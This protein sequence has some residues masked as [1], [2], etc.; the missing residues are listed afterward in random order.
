MK[1]SRGGELSF[2]ALR[3]NGLTNDDMQNALTADMVQE[4]HAGPTSKRLAENARKREREMSG[5]GYCLAGVQYAAADTLGICYSNYNGPKLPGCSS[6][7]ACFSNQAWEQSG[8]FTVFKFK[9][10]RENGN[11]CLKNPCAGAIVNFDRGKTKHGH[12]TISD[13]KG[14]YESDIHQSGARIASGIR[15]DGTPYGENYYIS[16]TN[17]CTVSDDLARQMLHE[18]YIREHPNAL[19][20]D[21]KRGPVIPERKTIPVNPVE[22]DSIS[23][24]NINVLQNIKLE[25]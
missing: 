3:R 13:G 20:N 7:S 4:V 5:S 1:G 10:D 2:D 25:R 9:N 18:R 6:N 23:N 8:K 17:D 16:F 12:V 15:A 21:N 11:E 19:V 22:I 24:I 14:G